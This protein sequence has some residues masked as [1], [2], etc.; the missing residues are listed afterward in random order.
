MNKPNPDL[1]VRLGKL[2]LKNPVMAA[3][4]TFGYGVEFAR[5]V[6]LNRLGAIVVKG[7]SLKPEQG[8][9]TPR[10]V[11]VPGGLLNAIGLQ[12]PGFEGF[13]RDYLPFLRQYQ[14]PVIVNIWGRT[15]AEYAAIAERLSAVA[16]VH[17]LELNIS[18]PNIKRGGLA[19]GADP[20]MARRVISAVRARTRLPLIPKLSPNVADI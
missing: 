19:F 17:G 14:T 13:V 12:N 6:D 11:E 16:G 15:T 8:N 20:R 18:C 5:L 4:G 10:L 1:S 7:L 2:V 3:S 9:P